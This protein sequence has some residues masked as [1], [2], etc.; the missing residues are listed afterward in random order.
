[1]LKKNLLNLF[2]YVIIVLLIIS[3]L[4]NVKYIILNINNINSWYFVILFRFVICLFILLKITNI[5][6]LNNNIKLQQVILKKNEIELDLLKL[7]T[8]YP[9]NV[10]NNLKYLNYIKV[11]LFII[12]VILFIFDIYYF[13]DII[14]N[15]NIKLLF[16]I[17]SLIILYEFYVGSK[18]IIG[19]TFRHRILEYYLAPKVIIPKEV[20]E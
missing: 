17:L 11:L 18:Y 8:L 13:Q 2:K 10:T 1:M 5:I 16:S 3:M 4:V 7:D 12:F 15:N 6:N 9:K 14:I 19:N 20:N